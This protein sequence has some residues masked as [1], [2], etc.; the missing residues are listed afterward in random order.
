MG[1]KVETVKA[2]IVIGVEKI[3]VEGKTYQEIVE[4]AIANN[5]AR[6]EKKEK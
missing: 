6:Q 3:I 4:L 2:E 5:E 1:K